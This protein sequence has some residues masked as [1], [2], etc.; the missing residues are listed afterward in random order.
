MRNRLT[1]YLPEDA[2]KWGLHDSDVRGRIHNQF[3]NNLTLLYSIKNRVKVLSALVE[4]LS[5]HIG[6]IIGIAAIICFGSFFIKNGTT[7]V[8]S[9]KSPVVPVIKKQHEQLDNVSLN[10]AVISLPAEKAVFLK[11][12]IAEVRKRYGMNGF[13]VGSITTKKL[14]IVISHRAISRSSIL[15]VDIDLIRWLHRDVETIYHFD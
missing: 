9:G 14:R 3:E 6:L 1:S 4:F 11:A 13:R 15:S 5:S 8:G 7:G 10:S 12:Y 2:E